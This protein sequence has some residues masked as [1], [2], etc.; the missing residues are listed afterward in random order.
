M[1]DGVPTKDVYKVLGTKAG[2]DRAFK[3]L[4]D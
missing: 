4:D 3:K 1:A 2:V